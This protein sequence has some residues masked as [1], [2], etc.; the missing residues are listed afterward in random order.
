MTIYLRFKITYRLKLHAR[1]P[2]PI[3][4]TNPMGEKTTPSFTCIE[5]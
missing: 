3:S 4:H 1:L 5:S 2:F